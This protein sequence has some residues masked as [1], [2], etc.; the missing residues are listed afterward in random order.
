MTDRIAIDEHLR[1]TVRPRLGVLTATVTVD[2]H[3]ERLWSTLDAEVETIRGGLALPEVAGHPEISALRAAYR[4]LGRDPQR[5][6][7]SAEALLRRTLQGKPLYRLNSVVDTN[8]LISLRHAMAVGSYDLDR[9]AGPIVFRAGAADERYNAIGKGDF[10][11]DRFPVFADDNGPFG[12]PTSDSERTMVR[13]STRRIAMV[14]ISFA[15]AD[16]SAALATATDL[17]QTHSD[18][19]CIDTCVVE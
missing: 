15:H 10:A 11:V 12:S 19:H 16:L 2:E 8:N 5:Y 4:A 9:T 6:R 13:V 18:A 14:L 7:G 17:L 1:K 3:D